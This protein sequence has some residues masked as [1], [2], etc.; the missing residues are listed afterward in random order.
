MN[1]INWQVC[2]CVNKEAKKAKSNHCPRLD[3]KAI[4]NVT[5]V[6][7]FHIIDMM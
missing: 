7:V 3:A 5:I 4:N 6:E 1:E 2:V